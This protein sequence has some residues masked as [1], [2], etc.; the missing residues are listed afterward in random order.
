MKQL[1]GSAENRFLVVD[2][3]GNYHPRIEIILVLTEHNYKF[4]G[5]DMIKERIP[6]TI[7]FFTD[8]EDLEKLIGQLSK[9]LAAFPALC[10]GAAAAMTAE[11]KEKK[12]KLSPRG[13]FFFLPFF[14][15]F[16]RTTDFL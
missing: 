9:A 11:N 10:R 2:A 15:L 16:S 1:S 8:Q 13:F 3:D 7:R 5:G 6:E 12:K 4:P 14:H